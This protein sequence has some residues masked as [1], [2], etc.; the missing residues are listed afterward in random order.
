[1]FRIV[2]KTGFIVIPDTIILFLFQKLNKSYS[3]PSIIQFFWLTLHCV[4][5]TLLNEE[6]AQRAAEIKV[7]R[8]I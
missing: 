8:S 5:L 6:Q 1:L 3:S 2:E 7:Q 4:F